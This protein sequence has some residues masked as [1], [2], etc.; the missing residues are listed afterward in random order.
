MIFMIMCCSKT[1]IATCIQPSKTDCIRMDIL[2]FHS[3][4]VNAFTSLPWY[5]CFCAFLQLVSTG[6]RVHDVERPSGRS[7]PQGSP[8]ISVCFS[9]K[10]TH[11]IHRLMTANRRS[12]S[13]FPC[14]SPKKLGRDVVTS[15]TGTAFL[16][17]R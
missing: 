3:W 15:A 9:A 14:F 13:P 8:K 17:T 12:T 11:S 4:Y 1:S 16:T 10:W 7:A 2:K 5:S 6:A